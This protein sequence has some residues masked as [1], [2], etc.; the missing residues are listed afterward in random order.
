M[1]VFAPS[2]LSWSSEQDARE[3]VPRAELRHCMRRPR[4]HSRTLWVL[5]ALPGMTSKNPLKDDQ[6]QTET[7]LGEEG[8]QP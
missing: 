1:I 8:E 2:T 3:M 6:N 4:L 7:R 5:Q